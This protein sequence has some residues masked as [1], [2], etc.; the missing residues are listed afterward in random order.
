[1]KVA[2]L[3]GTPGS[4][5]AEDTELKPKTMVEILHEKRYLNRL[6]ES[7]KAPWKTWSDAWPESTM[8]PERICRNSTVGVGSGT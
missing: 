6:W 3:A 5:L 2:T 8:S 4:C 1:M 7:G